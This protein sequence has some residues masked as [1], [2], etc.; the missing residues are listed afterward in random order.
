[1]TLGTLASLKYFMP[2][3]TLV[4][5][6]GFVLVWD[7]ILRGHRDR[8]K[9]VCLLTLTGLVLAGYFTIEL[10]S[11][12][13][14]GLFFGM[15]ALDHFGLLFRLIFIITALIVALLATA[16]CELAPVHRG[17]LF[18]LLIAVTVSMMWMANSINLLM[19]YVALEMVSITSY[20]MVGYL[21][22]ERLSNE[23]SLKY[24]LFGAVSTGVM[25]YGISFLFGLTGSLD[26]SSVR[27]ALQNEASLA[28]TGPALLFIVVL[29]FAGIGFKTAT[30]PFH[31]WTP[32]VYTGAPTPVTAFLSVGPKVAG[33]AVLV[34]FFFGGMAQPVG[35][36]DSSGWQM[37][38]T[39]DWQVVL[40]AIS[41][42]TMT[43]GNV[44][45]LI[46]TNL[47]RLLAYSSI[48]HAGYIL[49]GAVVLSGRGIQA[50][51]AYMVIY[52]FM[53]LGA[54]LVVIAVYDGVGSFD[55]EDY[56]GFW[57][58]SPI[59]TIAMGIFLLSLMGIPP[60]FGF[61]AKFYVFAAV[62]RAGLGWFAV[63]GVLNSVVAAF[64]YMKVI[65]VMFIEGEEAPEPR[66]LDV[67]PI[68]SGLLFVLLVPNIV[69]L[70][71]WEYLDRITEYSQR[72]LEV[73]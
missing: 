44:A 23:A 10:R 69:G 14:V 41:V 73:M 48:A 59:L 51:L 15:V 68:Y 12:P 28:G 65:K 36:S 6:L 1:M 56:A 35:E 9:L 5:T 62:I 17:E 53:N 63:V 11:A 49:M 30:V 32:D 34:R 39:V 16:S 54:F 19:I 70:L 2:E 18:A 66:R 26:L 61:L 22:R 13:E 58:R 64:Y 43:L 31:F 50:M 45:A 57:R 67:H 4:L 25:V 72:L 42:A 27:N 71:F 52:L 21:R 55:L 7:L 47:K 38:G 60:F 24:L 8:N 29:V 40:I 33:F 46:Q 37:L 3:L 20:I